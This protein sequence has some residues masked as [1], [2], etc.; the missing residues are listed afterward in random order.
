MF[1]STQ[2]PLTI[3]GV[4]SGQVLQYQEAGVWYRANLL[5]TTGSTGYLSLPTNS[6]P[7]SSTGSVGGLLPPSSASRIYYSLW[8]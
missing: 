4:G 2:S 3:P 6:A 8:S 7:T 5:G 1:F